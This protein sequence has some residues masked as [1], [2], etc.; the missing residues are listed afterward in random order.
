MR[1]YVM[2]RAPFIHGFV[3]AAN[4]ADS[5]VVIASNFCST[6]GAKRP[7][8]TCAALTSRHV[9]EKSCSKLS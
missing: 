9:T 3:I 1:A 2:K 7:V 5:F 8:V 6:R 4:L